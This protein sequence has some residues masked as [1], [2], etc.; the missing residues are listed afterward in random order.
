[1]LFI[2]KYLPL[3]SLNP[4]LHAHSVS[5]VQIYPLTLLRGGVMQIC[6]TLYIFFNTVKAQI[7]THSKLFDF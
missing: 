7:C 6:I 5:Q 4:H 3:Q 1:M 2:N